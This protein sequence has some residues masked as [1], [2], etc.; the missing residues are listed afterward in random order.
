M[1]INIGGAELTI[2]KHHGNILLLAILHRKGFGRRIALVELI[3][4]IPFEVDSV[5]QHE[6]GRI[7][8]DVGFQQL[9]DLVLC[10]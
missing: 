8:E 6:L 4:P 3:L 10:L 1:T 7:L 9:F 2:R 5:G